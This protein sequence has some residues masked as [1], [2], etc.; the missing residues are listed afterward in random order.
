MEERAEQIKC[1]ERMSVTTQEE[2]NTF[3]GLCEGCQNND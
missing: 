2:L 3:G 1:P